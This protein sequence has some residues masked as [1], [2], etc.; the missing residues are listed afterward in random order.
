MMDSNDDLSDSSSTYL[1]TTERGIF[2]VNEHEHV[3]YAADSA[4][5]TTYAR[6][7]TKIDHILVTAA[8]LPAVTAR[9]IEP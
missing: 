4:A 3:N 2:S 8:L 7:R 1:L 5:P 6:G 9:G